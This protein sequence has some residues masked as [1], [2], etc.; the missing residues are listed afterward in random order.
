[1][2]LH[3]S[4]SGWLSLVSMTALKI[5]GLISLFTHSGS[6]LLVADFSV[7]DGLFMNC[8]W[9]EAESHTMIA[10]WESRDV[11]ILSLKLSV[12]VQRLGD[13]IDKP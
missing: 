2:G 8:L 7:G 5:L 1:M 9:V 3:S 13:S 6:C 4:I 12:E 10:F 11:T